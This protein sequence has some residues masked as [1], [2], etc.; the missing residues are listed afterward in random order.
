MKSQWNVKNW[1]DTKNLECPK[2]HQLKTRCALT[3]LC[4]LSHHLPSLTTLQSLDED[5]TLEEEDE[6]LVEEED[7]IDQFN[8]DTFGAGAIGEW[9]LLYV[10]SGLYSNTWGHAVQFQGGFPHLL[11]K[12]YENTVYSFFN[13]KNL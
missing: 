12:L 13:P 2:L 1:Q 5:C 6:G 11:K 9:C 8:D 10:D 7:E 4:S 3:L